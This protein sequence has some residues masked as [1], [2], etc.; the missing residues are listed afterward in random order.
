MG[1]G[2]DV[3]DNKPH[4]AAANTEAGQTAPGAEKGNSPGRLSARAVL[5]LCTDLVSSPTP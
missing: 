2:L 5:V 4:L 1:T 3:A